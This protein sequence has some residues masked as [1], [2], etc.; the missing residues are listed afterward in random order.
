[1]SE[2]IP[3]N[4]KTLFD[5]A[6]LVLT[7]AD[8]LVLE[9]VGELHEQDVRLAERRLAE[10][11]RQL[12]RVLPS[13]IGR[14][15]LVHEVRMILAGLAGADSLV[16]QAGKGRQHIDGRI[17]ALGMETAVDDD[18]SFGD[19][20]GEVRDRVR[21]VVLGH[22]E[23]RN[24]RDR[25]LLAFDPACT[26]VD[27]GEVGVEIAGVTPPAGDLSAGSGDLA[28]RLA[29]VREVDQDD[30]HVH[31]LLVGQVL[32]RR[33]RHTGQRNPLDRRVIRK[34]HEQDGALD[35]AGPPKVRDE[36]LGF[37]E[38]DSHGGKD[39]RELLAGLEH[40]GL[41]GDLG[42][43]PGVG[44]TRAREE[45]EFLSPDQRI[46]EVDRGDPRLDEFVR[47]VPGEGVHGVAVHVQVLL[48][49]D[50]RPIVDRAAEPVKDPPQHIDGDT[51][52]HAFAEE[53]HLDV[54][55]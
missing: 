17:D 2:Q 32:G 3:A 9:G 37:L 36:E 40:F 26:L 23:N 50:G 29:V 45:R 42:R 47:V 44:K 25:P 14:V 53:L 21:F 41:T 46:E 48:R 19:V 51:E 49:D 5:G 30:Q 31:V 54:L 22:R 24:L 28:K 38:G 8:E 13:R 33:E 39:H 7:L 52:L 10:N 55:G 4:A 27:R 35:G 15:E 6:V 43:D 11:D 12:L 20:P 1:M 16:L 34:V 18:L